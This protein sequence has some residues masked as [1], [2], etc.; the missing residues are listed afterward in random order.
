MTGPL[1]FAFTTVPVLC[2]PVTPLPLPVPR[3]TCQVCDWHFSWH[4]LT[5][6]L[7]LILALALHWPSTPT[8]MSG[9]HNALHSQSLAF[10]FGV[11][12]VHVWGPLHSHLGSFTFAFVFVASHLWLRIRVCVCG[13]VFMFAFVALHLCLRLRSLVF[14]FAAS[15][16]CLQSLMFV[17]MFAVPHICVRVCSPLHLHLWP[18]VRVCIRSPLHS[19]LCSQSLVFIF[20]FAFTTGP[21]HSLCS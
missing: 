2:W 14:V 1:V 16:L 21:L 15:Y 20:M 6:G 9:V 10:M 12:H 4:A 11:L 19:C 8:P 17:F 3:A 5:N 13:L 18:C 7:A